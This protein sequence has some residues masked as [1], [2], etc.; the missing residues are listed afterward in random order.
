MRLPGR[1]QTA[2]GRRI[3]SL[4]WQIIFFNAAALVILIAGVL[5][6]QSSR[7]GLVDERM[8]GIKQEAR[9]V[10]STLAEYTTDDKTRSVNAD[11]AEPLLRQLI[12]PTQLRAR[13]YGTDGRLIIDTRNLLAHL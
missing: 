1:S 10:A 5:L 6:V 12:A 3:S 8:T 13:L 9:I 7:V 11:N 4:S 2:K